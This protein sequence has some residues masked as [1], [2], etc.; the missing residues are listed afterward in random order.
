MGSIQSEGDLT[1]TRWSGLLGL[2]GEL[3]WRTLR[4]VPGVG[5]EVL[6]DEGHGDAGTRGLWTARLGA[7]WRP[8]RWFE[9]RANGGYFERAPTLPEL[10]GDRGFVRGNATLRTERALNGDT[11]VVLH[12]TGAVLRGRLELVGYVRDVRDLI[13]WVQVN[14]ASF[15]AY[16]VSAA[17]VR[18][19]EVQGRLAWGHH[20][21]LVVSY[22][23]TDARV[24]D[25]VPV[26]SGR[27]VP[28]VPAHD[29]FV[30][31]TGRWAQRY[32]GS[33][34]LRTDL[35]FVSE[36]WLEE[37]NLATLVVPAR[38]LLG[39]SLTWEPSFVHGLSL[40]LSVSNLFDVRTVSRT[41]S[42]GVVTAPVLDFLGYPLPGRA[43]LATVTVSTTEGP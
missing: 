28:G 35:S 4:V 15:R 33:L 37:T 1:V 17:V 18:G 2:E 8:T 42:D 3:R 41:L 43:L 5:V 10:Y 7:S 22:A 30:A 9:V 11:G 40:G 39:A 13:A 34:A 19:I 36:A 25:G 24:A 12:R 38:T 31:V 16:N 26:V 32:L 6:S 23:H 29:L 20:V 21:E 14:R 27:R